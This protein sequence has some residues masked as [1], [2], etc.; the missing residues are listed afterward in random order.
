MFSIVEDLDFF[1]EFDNSKRDHFIGFK[2][3]RKLN[4]GH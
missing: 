2:K 4:Y 3:I 1:F